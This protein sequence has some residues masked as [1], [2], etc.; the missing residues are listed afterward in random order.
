MHYPSYSGIASMEQNFTSANTTWTFTHG[1]DYFPA[2]EVYTHVGG[3]ITKAQ[4]LKVEYPAVGEV[5]VTWSTARTGF[6]RIVTASSG[7]PDIPPITTQALGGVWDPAGGASLSNGNLTATVSAFNYVM[8]TNSATNGR[9]Y[10]ELTVDWT[11]TYA[12]IIGVSS[13]GAT[14]SQVGNVSIW[15]VNGGSTQL[16]VDNQPSVGYGVPIGKNSVIGILLDMTANTVEFFKDDV[17]MGV[18]ASN[19]TASSYKAYAAPAGSA[20]PGIV[21]ANFS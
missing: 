17:S 1:L 12:P 16:F 11:S 8:S 2:V 7:E 20:Y 21:T 6:I 3:I 14:Y 19:L 5:K 4:P 10:W 9:Y 18:A 15:P 13:G